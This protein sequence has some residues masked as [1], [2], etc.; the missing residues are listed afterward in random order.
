MLDNS[1]DSQTIASL[2]QSQISKDL[3]VSILRNGE[4]G[5]YKST[6]YEYM[7]STSDDISLVDTKY[8]LKNTFIFGTVDANFGKYW[9]EIHQL[10]LFHSLKSVDVRFLRLHPERTDNQR[11]Y[12]VRFF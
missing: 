2:V 4:W 7:N 3:S 5:F 1:P 12:K 9:N 11:T 10:T 8:V 6:P